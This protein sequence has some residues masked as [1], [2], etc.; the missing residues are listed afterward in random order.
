MSK[1]L[2][3]G[4]LTPDFA[5]TMML[6]LLEAFV[7]RLLGLNW[8]LEVDRRAQL[9]TSDTPIVVWRK[10]RR[11]DQFKG[12]SVD[13]A[14]ELRFPLDPGKQLVLSRRKRQRKVQIEA[15]RARRSNADMAAGSHRFIVGR[16]DQRP[17]LER[18]HLHPRPPVVRFNVG[19]LLVEDA[20]GRKVRDS[21]VLHMFVPDDR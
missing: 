8:T 5:V 7:P 15:H 18:V 14:D 19:P 4:V 6:Q 3:D 16:P 1:A 10:P 2:E 11:M 13:N 9:I 17:V 12:I 20:D 21:E